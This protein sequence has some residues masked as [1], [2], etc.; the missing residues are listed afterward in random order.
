MTRGKFHWAVTLLYVI[1][2]VTLN[3]NVSLPQK[4]VQTNLGP[5]DPSALI[6]GLCGSILVDLKVDVGRFVVAEGRGGR[7]L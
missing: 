7:G 4:A 1:L 3:C 6:V 5:D 2:S